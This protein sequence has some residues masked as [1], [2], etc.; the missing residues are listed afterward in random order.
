MTDWRSCE[1]CSNDDC[2]WDHDGAACNRWEP[3]R[4]RCGGAMS[5]LRT[6]HY[7]GG[8]VTELAKFDGKKYRHCFWC[9]SEFFEEERTD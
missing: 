6:Y 2:P 8:P 5:E 9:H 1:N 4:C 7:D 3:I